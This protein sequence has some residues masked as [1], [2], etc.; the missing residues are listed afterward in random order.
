MTDLLD[1]PAGARSSG[2]PRRRTA[3]PVTYPT[4]VTS[5]VA[6]FLSLA[7]GVV[8]GGE[9]LHATVVHDLHRQVDDATAAQRRAEAAATTA[10]A[11]EQQADAFTAGATPALVAGRLRGR[12]VAL[13][14]LPGITDAQRLRLA[15]AVRAAGGAVEDDLRLTPLAGQLASE[16]LMADLV[17]RQPPLGVAL[18]GDPLQQAATTLASATATAATPTGAAAGA[19]AVQGSG[20]ALDAASRTVAAFSASG[21]LT[22]ASR[23]GGLADSVLVMV[24]SGG[25]T[26]GQRSPGALATA[27]ATAYAATG[28]PTVIAVAGSR[29]TELAAVRGAPSHSSVSSVDGVDAPPGPVVTVLALAARAAGRVGAYGTGPGAT[30][31]LPG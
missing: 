22:G 15:G 9:V 12:T 25:P 23:V 13:V 2:P 1:A 21:L 29:G 14:S 27:V 3:P 5:L 28:A 24:S 19:P 26:D 7:V 8:V 17:A 6:V 30:A 31:V 11:H 4:L 18:T 10:H 20:T 16:Q